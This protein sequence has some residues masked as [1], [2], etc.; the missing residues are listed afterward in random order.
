MYENQF[1]VKLPFW[2]IHFA[3]IVVG[4]VIPLKKRENTYENYDYNI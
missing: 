1:N 4:K 2:K 3:N